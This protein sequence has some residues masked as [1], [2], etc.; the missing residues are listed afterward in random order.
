ML[1]RSTSAG[2]KKTKEQMEKDLIEKA[3]SGNKVAIRK[4]ADLDQIRKRQALIEKAKAGD[5][6]ASRELAEKFRI[7]KVY[8]QE[9]I[10]SRS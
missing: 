10:D 5:N 4:V 2:G 7:T 1:N 6:D 3:E 8:S 9:E